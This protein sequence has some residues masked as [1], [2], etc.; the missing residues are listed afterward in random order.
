[1]VCELQSHESQS[2]AE[3]EPL[4]RALRE[5]PLPPVVSPGCGARLRD[6][7]APTPDDTGPRLS[8]RRRRI[9][10]SKPFHLLLV[11]RELLW[12]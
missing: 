12:R 1:M 4:A 11:S 8:N 9:S 2:W 6:E 5:E 10:L 3:R 7:E